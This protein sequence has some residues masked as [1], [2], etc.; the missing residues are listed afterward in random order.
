VTPLK[1]RVKPTDFPRVMSEV[2]VLLSVDAGRIPPGTAVFRARDPEAPAR[3]LRAA[4]AVALSLSAVACALA[5]AARE[6]IALLG[7]ATG[8]AAVSA[9]ATEGDGA[10]RIVKRPMLVLTPTGMI[11]R[12]AFGLRSWQWHELREVRP[13]VHDQR[14]GLLF[15]QRDGARDF[16]DHNF[17]ERGERLSEMIGRHLLPRQT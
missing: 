6:L 13:F 7:L 16:V 11:V 17:F 2:E 8:I 10:E 9:S 14:L 3:I 1:A 5:G 4:L 15:V 12:D